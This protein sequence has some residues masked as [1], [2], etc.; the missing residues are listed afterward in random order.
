MFPDIEKW[1][2]FP[3]P[4]LESAAYYVFDLSP[5]ARERISQY[6]HGFLGHSTVDSLIP[7]AWSQGQ[8]TG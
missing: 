3:N 6:Y 7:D 2:V 5:E 4:S 8:T 1:I